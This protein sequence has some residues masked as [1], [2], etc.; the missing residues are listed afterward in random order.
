MI[1]SVENSKSLKGG[2]IK[3]NNLSDHEKQTLDLRREKD[4]AKVALA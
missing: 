2:R 3:T 1:S 4:Y